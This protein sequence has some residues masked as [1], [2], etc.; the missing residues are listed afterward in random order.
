MFRIVGSPTVPTM[1]TMDYPSAF[2][3]ALA[4]ANFPLKIGDLTRIE[5]WCRN[6][7]RSVHQ[8]HRNFS[9]SIV[10]PYKIRLTIPIEV[11]DSSYLPVGIRNLTRIK[12]HFRYAIN[13]VHPPDPDITC[14]RIVPHQ[15]WLTITVEVS[16]SN[17]FP[18]RIRFLARIEEW[19]R[20][21]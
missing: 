9:G 10:L 1:T 13:T 16:R 19:C 14:Y 6:Q 12:S 15:V 7:R 17:N 5:V 21:Q 3:D 8:P 2:R 18:V 11:A 20:N 4:I